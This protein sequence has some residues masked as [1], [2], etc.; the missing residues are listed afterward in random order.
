MPTR[1]R[2]LSNTVVAGVAIIVGAVAAGVGAGIGLPYASQGGTTLVTMAALF[3]L[4]VGAGLLVWGAISVARRRRGWARVPVIAVIAV[5]SVPVA[6]AFAMA[7][8]ATYV[9]RV[10]LGSETPSDRGLD[11]REV[12]F[13]A[14]DGVRLAGW[15]LPSTNGAAVILLH[16]AHSTR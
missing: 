6:F 7:T 12:A 1:G 13:E 5:V 8:A 10:A 2:P 3:C 14:S 16:G 4:A 15:Y 11:Y 9:P